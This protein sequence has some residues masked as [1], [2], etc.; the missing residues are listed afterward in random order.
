MFKRLKIKINIVHFI[1]YI[2]FL[3]GILYLPVI[4]QVKIL[5]LGFML[6]MEGK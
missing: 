4:W 1:G 6:F 5:L 3:I 2:I